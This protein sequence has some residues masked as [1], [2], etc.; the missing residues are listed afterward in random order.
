MGRQPFLSIGFTISFDRR[1][2]KW[3]RKSIDRVKTEGED[4][5]TRSTLFYAEYRN[6]GGGA[7]TEDRVDWPGFH[8]LKSSKEV[9][10]YTV[11]EL[12]QG[13]SWLPT[14]GVPYQSVV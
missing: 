13:D 9:R 7:C 4:D 5:S 8:V 12:I 6:T 11:S 1:I 14:S 10:P 2:L 3:T